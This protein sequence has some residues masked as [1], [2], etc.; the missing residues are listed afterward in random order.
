MKIALYISALTISL[1]AAGC[2]QPL[3]SGTAISGTIW[4]YPR[5]SASNEG[6][7]FPEDSRVDVYDRL[8]IIHLADGSRRVVQLDLVMDLTLK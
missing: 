7:G 4:K 3:S 6:S 5:T 1:L 2:S 8:I